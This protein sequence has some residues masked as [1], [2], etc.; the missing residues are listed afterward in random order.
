MGSFDAVSSTIPTSSNAGGEAWSQAQ[1]LA[2]LTGVDKLGLGNWNDI[3]VQVLKSLHTPQECELRFRDLRVSLMP[4]QPIQTEEP[5]NSVELNAQMKLKAEQAV[6]TPGA[7]LI[8]YSVLREDFDNVFA[9]DFEAQVLQDMAFDENLERQHVDSMEEWTKQ[10][11]RVLRNYNLRI[12]EREYR[13]SVVLRRSLLD[14]PR[15]QEVRNRM[16]NP[17]SDVLIGELDYFAKFATDYDQF[18]TFRTNINKERALRTELAELKYM[19]SLGAR[20]VEEAQAMGQAK[21]IKIVASPDCKTIQDLTQTNEELKQLLQD[22][23]NNAMIHGTKTANGIFD[24]LVS[25]TTK[26]QGK[27]DQ[28]L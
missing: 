21:R 27:D 23:A 12:D 25:T 5:Y 7:H 19:H 6:H 8:G 28:Q 1:D 11:L 17:P 10:K 26:Q 20:T 2:L 24:L 16:N 13:K 18:L 14:F 3:S 9:N 15:M 22:D 4:N